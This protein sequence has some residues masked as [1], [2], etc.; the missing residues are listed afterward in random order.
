MKMLLDTNVVLDVLLARQPFLQD[1]ASLVP[2]IEQQRIHG[3]LCATTVTTDA[4]LVT[5][6][7]GAAAA[8]TALRRLLDLFDVATVNRSIL[9]A[10]LDLPMINFEDAV[11]HEAARSAGI[12]GI[13]TR[14]VK[15]F[16]S[17]S[18]PVYLPRELLAAYHAG[19]SET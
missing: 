3:Y 2:L 16:S 13:I 11:L 8:H 12:D 5:K 9:G 19:E 18:L 4:Y 7:K 17:A 15:N 6:E 10:A 14:N 1:A